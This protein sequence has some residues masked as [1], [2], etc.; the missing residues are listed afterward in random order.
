MFPFQLTRKLLALQLLSSSASMHKR[1]SLMMNCRFVIESLSEMNMDGMYGSMCEIVKLNNWILLC[2]FSFTIVL[3]S[4]FMPGSGRI[5][6]CNN[7]FPSNDAKYPHSIETQES[8]ANISIELNSICG[9]EHASIQTR[10]TTDL[11]EIIEP[12]CR[13][14]EITDPSCRCLLMTFVI[15]TRRG[16]ECVWVDLWW[17][18]GLID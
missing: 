1:E 6:K 13:F 7:K 10:E 11:F 17:L 15:R 12:S 14:P 5:H 2:R 16:E 4:L 9:M 18:M 3:L 8:I